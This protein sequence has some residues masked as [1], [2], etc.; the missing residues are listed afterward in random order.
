MGRVGVA[1][2]RCARVRSTPAAPGTN[3]EADPNG[4]L[5]GAEIVFTGKLSQW[6][7]R[8]AW[9]L[10]AER[11]AVIKEGVTR[12]TD[13]LVCGVQDPSRLKSD[14]MSAKMRKALEVGPSVSLLTELEFTQML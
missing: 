3:P 1:D 4:T 7:R 6:C 14:G 12:T 13:Y 11:G 10:A 2:V 5:Y 9:G 8:E